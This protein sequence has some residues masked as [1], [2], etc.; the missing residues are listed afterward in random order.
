MN[1]TALKKLKVDSPQILDENDKKIID[2]QSYYDYYISLPHNIDKL[3]GCDHI[4]TGD[5]TD[6]HQV[7]IHEDKPFLII[8]KE[9]RTALSQ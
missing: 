1:T 7:N 4:F 2:K 9:K 3:V 8:D 6:L 5:V